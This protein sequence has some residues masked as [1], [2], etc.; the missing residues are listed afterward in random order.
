MDDRAR[1]QRGGVLAIRRFREIAWQRHGATRFASVAV[2]P[3]LVAMLAPGWWWAWCLAFSAIGMAID[4]RTVLWMKRLDARLDTLS[5]EETTRAQSV[6][7]GRVAALVT[8]YAAPYAILS[9]SPGLGPVVGL[10]FALGSISVMTSLHVLT[11]NMIFCTLPPM[12]L[13]LLLNAG[14]LGQSIAEVAG[15]GLLCAISLINSIVMARAGARAFEDTVAARVEAESAA[16]ELER[17]V[18]ERTSELLAA[19][20]TAEAASKAKSLFLANMSHEL[21]TPLNAVIGYSEI[22]EEDLASGDVAECPQ[23]IARVRASALH[24]LGLIADVLDLAKV[25]AEKIVLRP[26]AIDARA[27]AR[28]VLETVA[29][30]AASNGA[31]CELVVEPGADH[32]VADPLRVKQCLMNLA[33]NAAKFTHNGRIVLHLR[34]TMKDARDMIAFDVIDTGI[35]I[36]PETQARL[37]E[38][39]VQ[40]D[41]SIT[42]ALGGT[43]L[44]LAITRRF[45]RIMGGDVTVESE[46]GKG[47][48]FTLMLPIAPDAVDSNTDAA[49][50]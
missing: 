45:A 2:V 25:E 1:N 47:S 33:S 38:P 31:S 22:I 42:R 23:H 39:F 34:R 29:P 4:W 41:A 12:G 5:L 49:A 15:L 21:R 32:I 11:R 10:M 50:A 48:R 8:A 3:L 28:S 9:F 7:I 43:G 20:Q 27:L 44:G 40:A 14:A 24:L 26:E 35:G 30:T 6:L 16:D 18:A 36:S 46:V 13:A 19:M 17:R 37:F